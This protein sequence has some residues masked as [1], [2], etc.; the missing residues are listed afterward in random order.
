MGMVLRQRGWSERTCDMS[1]VRFLSIPFSIFL[2]YSSARTKPALV[3]RFWRYMTCFHTRKCLFGGRVHTAPDFGVKSSKT[4]ILCMWIDIFKLNAQNIKT[5]IPIQPNFVQRQRPSN[6]LREW[7]KHV[8]NKFKIVNGR[9]LEKSK[10]GHI[11]ATV[12]PINTHF[13]MVKHTGPP[14]WTES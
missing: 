7:S 14:N 4:P 11:T 10:I 8:L 3:D 1:H 9:H 12:R 5:C 13:G 2:R 6:T